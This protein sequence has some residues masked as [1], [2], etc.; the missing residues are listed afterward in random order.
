MSPIDEL[1]FLG[2]A[3]RQCNLLVKQHGPRFGGDAHHKR[4]DTSPCVAVV[5]AERDADDTE[6]KECCTDT[7]SATELRGEDA[8][9]VAWGKLESRGVVWDA[10]FRSRD[11]LAFVHGRCVATPNVYDHSQ[12]ITA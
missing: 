2:D 4:R 9:D 5:D 3:I 7:T 11:C 10:E 12:P 8:E 6:D 1:W